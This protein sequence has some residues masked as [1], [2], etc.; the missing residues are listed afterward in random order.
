MSV[1]LASL[2]LP[3]LAAAIIVFFA[4]FVIWSV[5]QWHNSDW[6]KLPD[7]EAARTALKGTPVGMYT[8]PHAA[9]NK[10]RQSEAWM[11]KYRE[12]PAAMLTMLPHG[13]LAM[14]KQLVQWFVYCVIVSLLVAYVGGATL[15]AGTD[16]L[17]VFQVI[18]T[19]AFLAYAGSAGMQ[20]I[21]FGH[22]WG[23]TVKDAIDGL[24]YGLL[25][26]GVFGWMWPAA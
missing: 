20:A 11:S 2:W 12:G 19:V 3:I 7:E 1:G 16:Y 26:A 25:T 8:L 9:D 18:G 24:I 10:E 5:L 4:S 13:T 15:P 22:P 21:W 6:R 23:K 14:G 17:K